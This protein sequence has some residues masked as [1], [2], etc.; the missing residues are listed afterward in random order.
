MHA[1]VSDDWRVTVTLKERGH[2]HRLLAVLHEHELERD[3]RQR[4]GGTVAVSGS[5]SSVFLYADGKPAA[6][7]AQRVMEDLAAQHGFEARFEL[8]QWH[9]VEERWED[10]SVPLPTTQEQWER[11]HERREE[12][13]AAQS[14]SSRHALWEVRVELPSH[15]DTVALAD[16]LQD[17][18]LSVVR[19][20]KFLL[21]GANSEDQ[22][23]M[24][25]DQL[26]REAPAGSNVYAEPSPAM[27]GQVA[28]T[29]PFRLF[30]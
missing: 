9:P 10:P 3:A 29:R 5:D 26:E 22:A 6:R 21:V 19:R 2:A 27:V 8:A 7:H 15:R 13:E 4:L 23:K 17:E 30:W 12:S 1:R 28:A 11:E 25:A 14:E 20:W 24:L 16:R 18:G